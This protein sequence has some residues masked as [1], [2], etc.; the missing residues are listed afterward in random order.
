MVEVETHLNEEAAAASAEIAELI[1][2]VVGAALSSPFGEIA[3]LYAQLRAEWIR[4][5]ANGGPCKLVSPW[6]F[7]GALIPVRK[8]AP[9]DFKMWWTVFEPGQGWGADEKFAAHASGANRRWP[10]S[11]T[12][13]SARTAAAMTTSS[14]TPSTARRPAGPT[15]PSSAG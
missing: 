13:L 4:R 1:G 6:I 5:V 15:T 14:G 10:C 2:A 11:M 7:P 8:Q 9:E 12:A 3:E